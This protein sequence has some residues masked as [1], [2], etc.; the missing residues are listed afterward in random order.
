MEDEESFWTRFRRSRGAS[1]KTQYLLIQAGSLLS[2]GNLDLVSP[3]LALVDRVLGEHV[4]E[5]FLSDA[6]Y[7]RAQC[8]SAL[9]RCDEAMSSY[10]LSFEARRLRPGMQNLAYLDFAWLLLTMERADLYDE[11]LQVLDEF[12]GAGELFP[13]HAYKNAAARALLWAGLNEKQRAATYAKEAIAASSM[14]ESPFRHH[15]LLGIVDQIDGDL[16]ARLF[17]LAAAAQPDGASPH[18]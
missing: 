1:S 16:Q 14:G 3:A 2:A 18:R 9:Q 4:D 5:A 15:R 8:L 11:A 13:L 12:S 17:G 7:T 10:R 6:H